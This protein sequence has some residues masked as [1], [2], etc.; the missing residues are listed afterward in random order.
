MGV[1]RPQIRL[2]WMH[3]ATLFEVV[4]YTW[5]QAMPTADV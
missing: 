5:L 4:A 2:R 3:D 1:D